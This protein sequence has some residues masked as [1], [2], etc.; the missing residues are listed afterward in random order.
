MINH[1]SYLQGSYFARRVPRYPG[2]SFSCS[3]QV[4]YRVTRQCDFHADQH[5]DLGVTCDKACHA[6][7]PHRGTRDPISAS[8]RIKL[9][10]NFMPLYVNVSIAELVGIVET[11]CFPIAA[12]SRRPR[13]RQFQTRDMKTWGETCIFL[14]QHT[15]RVDIVGRLAVYRGQNEAYHEA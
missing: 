11:L 2:G 12:D 8:L 1:G 9:T 7:T 3:L 5:A 6:L 14:E 10:S 15:K 13:G 4:P